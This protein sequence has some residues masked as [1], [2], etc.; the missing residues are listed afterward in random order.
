MGTSY[1]CLIVDDE[2]PAHMVIKSHISNCEDLE[3]GAS[4]YNGKEAIKLLNETKFDIL[5][6]D[7]DMPLINGVELMETKMNRPPTIITTA[8]NHF[9]FDAY[10]HDAIDYLLKPISFSRFLKAT[11]KIKN[12]KSEIIETEVFMPTIFLKIEGISR[13][14][15]V[16]DILYFE[17]IG[18]YLKVYFVD[19]S[20]PVIVYDSLKN[21]ISSTPTNVF[22]Q[23]HKSYIVNVEYL[24]SITKEDFVLK[25][26]IT[27]P[28][29]RKYEL[30]VNNRINEKST[31]IT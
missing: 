15:K 11:Q 3:F 27:L 26:N 18:N 30:L 10:Q 21:I 17:S 24:L 4:A 14:Y 9:A 16:A 22:I 8:Y 1:K 12:T 28:L 25:G 7:I 2:K 20:K 13:E 31:N 19:K 6:L 23:T 29:G 5:F